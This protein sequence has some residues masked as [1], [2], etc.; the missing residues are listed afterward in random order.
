MFEQENLAHLK[1]KFSNKTKKEKPMFAQN[2]QT[3]MPRKVNCVKL[4][5]DPNQFF[6]AKTMANLNVVRK[7]QI[8]GQNFKRFI[9][10]PLVSLLANKRKKKRQKA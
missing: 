2:K 1:D 3:K 6:F 8:Q 10:Q 4:T 5:N 9:D 7:I